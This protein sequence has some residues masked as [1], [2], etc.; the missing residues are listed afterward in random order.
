MLKLSKI[1]LL[2]S[3]VLPSLIMFASSWCGNSDPDTISD[4]GAD[5]WLWRG[6]GG[7][8]ENAFFSVF[9]LNWNDNFI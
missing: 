5:K 3:G 8:A 4:S 6:G 2:Y 7:G 1:L 9:E